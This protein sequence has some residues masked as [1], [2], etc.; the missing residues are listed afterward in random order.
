MPAIPSHLSILQRFL[1]TPSLHTLLACEPGDRLHDSLRQHPPRPCLEHAE[2]VRSPPPNSA[3]RAKNI[4]QVT[5]QTLKLRQVTC[6]M[7]ELRPSDLP[8]VGAAAK[9]LAPPAIKP[10]N[11]RTFGQ[12]VAKLRASAGLFGKS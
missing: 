3:A 8:D 6:R 11:F 1:R 5:C 12:F 10:E 4:G 7:L 2:R 9:K